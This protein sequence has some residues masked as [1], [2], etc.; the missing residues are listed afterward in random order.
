[1]ECIILFRKL[2]ENDDWQSIVPGLP[3]SKSYFLGEKR[4]LPTTSAQSINFLYYATS[5]TLTLKNSA[6]SVD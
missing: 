6:K 5:F 2:V 3:S 1:M 4:K